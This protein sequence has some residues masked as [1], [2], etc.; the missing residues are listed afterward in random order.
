MGD[1]LYLGYMLFVVFCYF[2]RE[3]VEEWVYEYKVYFERFRY[4]I[5]D[6]ENFCID[7]LDV[8]SLFEYFLIYED[9]V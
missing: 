7:L 6:N 5:K 3:V 4:F 1:C 2:L 9:F 8:L